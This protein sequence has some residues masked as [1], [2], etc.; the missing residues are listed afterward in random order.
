MSKNTIR[1]THENKE[2]VRYAQHLISKGAHRTLSQFHDRPVMYMFIVLLKGKRIRV[3][4]GYTDDIFDTFN[5][6]HVVYNDNVF[7]VKTKKVDN[8]KDGTNFRKLIMAEHKNLVSR[9]YGVY[10]LNS[11]LVKEFDNYHH[12]DDNPTDGPVEEELNFTDYVAQLIKTEN[13]EHAR[14]MRKLAIERTKLDTEYSKLIYDNRDKEEKFL[15]LE[16][17]YAKIKYDGEKLKE[18]E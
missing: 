15:K 5:K 13:E 9:D 1:Y 16:A 3:K 18:F 4:I 11:V 12:V 8:K 14:V 10:Y 2:H 7:F 6:A 17:E